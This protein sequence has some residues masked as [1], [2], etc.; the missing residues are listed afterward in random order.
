M[1]LARDIAKTLEVL[2]TRVKRGKEKMYLLFL[3]KKKTN[4]IFPMSVRR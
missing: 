3:Q 1:Q 4:S 2:A